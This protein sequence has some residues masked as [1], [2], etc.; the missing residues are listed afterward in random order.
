LTDLAGRGPIGQ[1]PEKAPR[2]PRK[3]LARVSA[4]KRKHKAAEKA[5]G[6]WEHMARVKALPCIAC[7]APPPSS[8]HHVT[9][10]KQPRSDWRVI[11]L[12]Y[13]CHQGPQGYHAA[14]RSWVARHGPDYGFLGL[15]AEKLANL[16]D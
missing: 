6:S 15:V 14:K 7:G 16:P 11:P 3:P 1:K 10:D 9:G 12:C 5:A 2:K 8:A 13:D 4:R